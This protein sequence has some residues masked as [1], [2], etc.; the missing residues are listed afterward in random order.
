LAGLA[1]IHHRAGIAIITGT[2]GRLEDTIAIH[3][4][5]R[6]TGVG[7]IAGHLSTTHAPSIDAGIG[8][9]AG[10]AV[11]ARASNHL[12]V[13]AALE[14]AAIL[15]AGIAI[16]ACQA[17]LTQTS[18]LHTGI[19]DRAF[20]GIVARGSI[21]TKHTTQKGITGVISTRTPVITDERLASCLAVP[22]IAEVAKGTGITIIARGSIVIGFTALR[23]I[24]IVGRAGIGV[25]TDFESGGIARACNASRRGRTRIPII[26]DFRVGSVLTPLPTTCII[27]TGIGVITL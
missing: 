10:I 24:A 25:I 14:K 11:T 23:W 15:G 20:I 17:A 9:G 7:V 26:T 22:F 19:T 18:S 8:R 27:R 2:T 12:V 21:G 16:V 1:S 5:F 13:T 6:G 4:G 3:T